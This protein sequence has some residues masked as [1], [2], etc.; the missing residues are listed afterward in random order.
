MRNKFG[1]S[2]GSAANRTSSS[3]G[4]SGA[5]A[6]SEGA[7]EEAED[8]LAQAIRMSLQQAG[9]EQD[10]LAVP[11]PTT[12]AAVGGDEQKSGFSVADV[13]VLDRC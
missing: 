10:A 3:S 12:L 13:S 1:H 8:E 4:G 2:V 11:D 6:V 7:E 9:D 5:V